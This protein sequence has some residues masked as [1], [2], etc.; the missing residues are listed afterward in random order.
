MTYTLSEHATPPAVPWAAD[1][2]SLSFQDTRGTL[3]P[4]QA[5]EGPWNDRDL[6]STNKDHQQTREVRNNRLR[7]ARSIMYGTPLG[8]CMHATID[9]AGSV[10][11]RLESG[12]AS[13]Q[14]Y[15]RC[16]YRG[17]PWCALIHA[18]RDRE[19]AEQY[20]HGWVKRGSSIVMLAFT[21]RHHAGE[22]LKTTWDVHTKVLNTLRSG[23][24]WRTFCK[25]YHLAE[26]FY[27]NEIT[28]GL[29][30]WHK[31]QH[32]DM[33]MLA[34]AAIKSKAGRARVATQMKIDLDVLY[35]NALA[36]H[37]RSASVEH[38]IDVR[39]VVGDDST[40]EIAAAYVTKSAAEITAGGLKSG[41]H[42]N[43]TPWELL[44]DVENKAL[45]QGQRARAT[46]RYREF[47]V[48]SKGRHWTYFSEARQEKDVQTAAS[49]L[50]MQEEDC[51]LEA[52][53]EE[54][55]VHDLERRMLEFA[56]KQTYL[57]DL[58]ENE[59]LAACARYI[60]DF[61]C[62]RNWSK[63]FIRGQVAASDTP[64]RPAQPPPA[65]TGSNPQFGEVIPKPVPPTPEEL[66]ARGSPWPQ[67]QPHTYAWYDPLL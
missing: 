8:L 31:H 66:A 20:L 3:D 40:V 59:G 51:V 54:L 12:V 6:L 7:I 55:V 28:D 65:T 9:P 11:L 42:G 26:Y 48:Q 39:I 64:R 56:R 5:P 47:V 17:C 49:E 1:S 21:M 41:R 33:E 61:C 25:D 29:N 57:L 52:A 32:A 63:Q 19:R 16:N 43:Q 45:S 35:N 62:P 14:G 4:V 67:P 13:W 36:K 60:D 27:A 38:G 50:E 23:R 22:E 15:K 58:A 10:T 46:A 44:D 2:K 18:Q 53:P 34:H 24:A 30:G 37:G